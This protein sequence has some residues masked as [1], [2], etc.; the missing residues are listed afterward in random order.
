MATRPT[1]RATHGLVA[2]GHHL[3]TTAGVEALRDGGNAVDAAVIAAA[4]CAV[5]LPARTSIGGDLFALV[6]DS[7]SRSVRAYN[8]SGRSPG[9]IA[10]DRFPDGFPERGA[11]TVTV[12]GVI[13]A[14]SDLLANHGTY[15][16]ARVLDPAIR[17]A[18]DGFPVSDL[19]VDGIAAHRDAL[20]ADPGSAATFLPR[21]RPP[22][23]GE[24]P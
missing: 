6:Y 5:V 24:V 9:A 10:L 23:P 21:G 13:A 4:V 1:I 15:D 11:L 12:P 18:D 16:L 3:A 8:G 20:S 19:L 22:R 7:R 2:S 17:Y 14:W